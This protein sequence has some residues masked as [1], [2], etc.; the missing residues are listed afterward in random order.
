M[1]CR[2]VE[3]QVWLTLMRPESHQAEN[4]INHCPREQFG[5]AEFFGTRKTRKVK[6]KGK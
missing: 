1:A 5:S 3:Q 2:G 6:G 4:S